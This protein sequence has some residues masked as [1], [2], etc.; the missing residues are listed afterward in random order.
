MS[1]LPGT[2]DYFWMPAIER[3]KLKSEIHSKLNLIFYTSFRDIAKLTLHF[4]TPVDVSETNAIVTLERHWPGF[5]QSLLV[6]QSNTFHLALTR[7][8]STV[9]YFESPGVVVKCFNL[10]LPETEVVHVL[11]F[12][13]FG[14]LVVHVFLQFTWREVSTNLRDPYWT[15]ADWR[16]WDK[17]YCYLRET[18]IGFYSKSLGWS[19][20]HVFIWP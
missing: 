2:A 4:R 17:C 5:T 15:L 3:V 6:D 14:S 20:E 12:E 11:S 7:E 9:F 8:K 18:L 19:V 16:L 13:T 1:T 10:D